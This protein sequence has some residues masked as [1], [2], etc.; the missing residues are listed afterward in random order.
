MEL[1]AM[2]GNPI[3]YHEYP[4]YVYNDTDDERNIRYHVSNGID[5][6][7]TFWFDDTDNNLDNIH[8]MPYRK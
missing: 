6:V 8:I 4:D 7:V 5:Y 3:T 2:L 1:I